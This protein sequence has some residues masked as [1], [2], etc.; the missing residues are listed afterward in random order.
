MPARVDVLTYRAALAFCDA[1]QPATPDAARFSLQHAVAVAIVRGAPGIADFEGDMLDHP[2]V[3]ALR[4]RITLHCDPELDMAFPGRLTASVTITDAHGRV[5]MADCPAAWGD[6]EN[7][8]SVADLDAKFR[9][10][11]AHGGLETAAADAIID[12]VRRLD[13]APT[14]DSFADALT[15]AVA[16]FG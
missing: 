14:L 8:M 13:R 5:R 4:T 12:A 10:N 15:C 7:P 1:P 2:A 6:P 3:A 16:P 9:A 11:A